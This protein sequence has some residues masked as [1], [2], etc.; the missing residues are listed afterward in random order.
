MPRRYAW[1]RRILKSHDEEG[2]TLF[3]QSWE[4]TRLLVALFADYTRTDLE[5]VLGKG[6]PG[7]TVLLEALQATLDFETAMSKRLDMPVSL[8]I[9]SQTE[10]RELTAQFD[11]V[12][13][14]ALPGQASKGK[15]RISTVFDSHFTIYVDAQDR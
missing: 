4:V 13:E 11:D 5:N 7:V 15:W 2:D 12:A 1:F 3:P 8:P 6:V 14:K 10:A 9:N